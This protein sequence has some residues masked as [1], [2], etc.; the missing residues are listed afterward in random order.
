MCINTRGANPQITLH[1][2]QLCYTTHCLAARTL[3]YVHYRSLFGRS[4]LVLMLLSTAYTSTYV[5]QSII[6]F[7]AR[8]SLSLTLSL[9]LSGPVSLRSCSFSWKS[10]RFWISRGFV[11]GCR[12]LFY[13]MC[14][15]EESWKFFY[16]S[17]NFNWKQSIKLKMPITV[18]IAG[19]KWKENY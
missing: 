19:D 7:S 10:V 5:V 11:E 3:A 2:R 18:F 8:H 16:D 12:P 15:R 4:V 14:I 9:S 17:A 6:S 13:F 1:A